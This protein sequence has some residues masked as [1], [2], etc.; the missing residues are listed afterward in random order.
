LSG[1]REDANSAAQAGVLLDHGADPKALTKAGLQGAG[2]PFK[3]HPLSPLQLAVY[4][5]GWDCAKLL[6]R[7]GADPKQ[8]GLFDPFLDPAPD[9]H[10]L[11][12]LRFLLENGADPNA[13]DAKG[14]PILRQVVQRGDVELLK[15]F[16]KHGA[17]ANVKLT[18]SKLLREPGLGGPL[19]ATTGEWEDVPGSLLDCVG[20][21]DPKAALEIDRL[22]LDAGAKPDGYLGLVLNRVALLDE[23][24]ELVRRLLAQRPDFLNLGEIR[25]LKD[26]QPA[27]RRIFLDEVLIPALAKEPGPLLF[28]AITGVRQPLVAP[29]AA[30][31]PLSTPELLVAQ[32]GVWLPD[33]GRW[34][35]RENGMS[36]DYSYSFYWPT[37]TLV[38]PGANAALERRE[39][40][41]TGDEPLP[42][43]RQGDLLELGRAGNPVPGKLPQEGYKPNADLKASLTWHLRKRITFPVTLELDGKV[44]E[45]KLRGDLLVFD[46]TR[47]EAP[48]FTAGNLA[49]LFLPTFAAARK[50]FDENT[51]LT[52]RRQGAAEVRMD[53][54]ASASHRFGLKAGDHLILPDTNTIL[55][56]AANPGRE[57]VRLVIPGFPYART[58]EL[59]PPANPNLMAPP[60]TLV[61]LLTD[62]YFPHAERSPFLADDLDEDAYPT[63]TNQ[64]GE[65]K[66]PVI[67]PHPDLAHLRIRRTAADGGETVIEVDLTEAIRR[68][69]AETPPAEARQADLELQPGDVVELPLKA[70]LLGQPWHGFSEEE[71]RFFQKALGGFFTLKT[72][73]GIMVQRE[74]LYHQPEWRQTPHGLLPLPPKQGA[75][76]VRARLVLQKGESLSRIERGNDRLRTDTS[77]VRDGDQLL[78][79][80]GP[81]APTPPTAPTPAPP[82]S[83]IRSRVMPPSAPVPPPSER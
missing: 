36:L 61:Q 58:Y 3:S 74:I 31:P 24:G 80:A 37:L 17:D 27:S 34:K 47:N 35:G 51:L 22:L 25:G 71:E 49:R 13:A 42:E 55:R 23:T 52:V 77:F 40:D 81:Q 43:L 18:G 57:P 50:P 60:P 2:E 44:R 66:V 29:D 62:A 8:P 7:R 78:V 32:L 59:Q 21:K 10:S 67:P 41:L 6:L 72:G 56:Q 54:S 45:I 28:S 5:E 9:E 82:P 1:W 65:Q 39:L 63:L 19:A 79:D 76:S 70:D 64:D 14:K 38:R 75:A 12:K 69:C 68:C 15:L 53:L 48:L 30:G 73:E 16:L 20:F 46:P 4:H 33:S 11:A 83:P 26:W